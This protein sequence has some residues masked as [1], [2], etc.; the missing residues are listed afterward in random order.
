LTTIANPALASDMYPGYDQLGRRN[1]EGF[2]TPCSSVYPQSTYV[3]YDGQV[4]VEEQYNEVASDCAS[5]W[6][7]FSLQENMLSIPAAA[8]CW[9]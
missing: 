1:S 5:Y 9:P 4:P 3:L 6:A 7:P 8:R 2:V